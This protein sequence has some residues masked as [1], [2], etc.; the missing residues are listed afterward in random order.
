MHM[1]RSWQL[2][3]ATRDLTSNSP[4]A[5]PQRNPVPS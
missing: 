3:T 5:E 4:D 2:S 1:G